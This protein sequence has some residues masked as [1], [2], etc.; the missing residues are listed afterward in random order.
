MPP[1]P[2]IASARRVLQSGSGP[3]P[4]MHYLPSRPDEV[5][6]GWLPNAA[7]APVMEV[8]SGDTITIDTVSHEGILE[9]QGSDPVRFLAD[10]GVRED[11]VLDDMIAIAAD[12]P[13]R[14][15]DDGPHV[16]TGPIAVSEARAGDVLR[17]DVMELTQ[18]APYGFISMRHGFGA[19]PDELPAEGMAFR[20]FCEVDAVQGAAAGSPSQSGSCSSRWR[21]SWA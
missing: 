1:V 19:L 6:W 8:S 4:G 21:P 13:D 3:L 7:T 2:S 18:R 14:E 17:I 5:H 12:G 11:E 20:H 10:F 16:V 15:I 9:D